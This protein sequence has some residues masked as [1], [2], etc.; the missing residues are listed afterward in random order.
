MTCNIELK[1]DGKVSIPNSNYLAPPKKE[2]AGNAFLSLDGAC[3]DLQRVS[4]DGFLFFFFSAK[5]TG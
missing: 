2:G 4:Q 3:C 5:L 1:G